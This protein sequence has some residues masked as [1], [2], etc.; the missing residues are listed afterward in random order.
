MIHRWCGGKGYTEIRRSDGKMQ[1][2]YKD[3]PLY[4]WVKDKKPGDITEDG[5]LYGASHTYCQAITDPPQTA[6]QTPVLPCGSGCRAN[7][8]S[9]AGKG[10]E[11]IAA[12]PPH[13][14]AVGFPPLPLR[15]TSGKAQLTGR[16]TRM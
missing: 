2:A 13:G 14:L 4:A 12:L 8:V 11:P 1:W 15:R 10:S 6:R 16:K 9:E 5:Y 3:T 7:E